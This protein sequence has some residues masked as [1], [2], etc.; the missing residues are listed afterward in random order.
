MPVYEQKT[1]RR[2]YDRTAGKC[3]ICHR[4][5]AFV[6]YGDHGSRGAWEVEHSKPRAHGGSDHGNNLF[7]AHIGCN[8]S[9]QHNST[10]SARAVHGKTRAPFSVTKREKIRVKNTVVGAGIGSVIGAAFGPLGMAIGSGIGGYIGS[11][12][13]VE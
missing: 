10:R 3:H 4:K 8:R 13:E 11:S 2:I 6:N 1:L 12:A 7:A 9:K 5:L